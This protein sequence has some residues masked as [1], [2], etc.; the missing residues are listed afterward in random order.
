MAERIQVS[1]VKNRGNHYDAHERIGFL[2]GTHNDKPW[3]MSENDIIAELEKSGTARG[4]DFVVT[5]GDRTMPVVVA[6]F[7]GRK[8]LKTQGDGNSPD[9]LLSL[10][11]CP[12]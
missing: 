2:G 11:D 7:K 5:V 4:W 9:N 1:C 12:A 6:M 10:P 3:K 8:Y